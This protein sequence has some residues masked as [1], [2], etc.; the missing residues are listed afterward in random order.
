MRVAFFLL[1]IPRML[2]SIYIDNFK[3]LVNFNLNF[4]DP[5]TVLIGLNGAGKTTLL[6]ALDFLHALFVGGTNV[7]LKA[8]DW[9]PDDVF[10]SAARSEENAKDVQLSF[11]LVFAFLDLGEVEWS[12]QY[13]NNQ[14]K[15]LNEKVTLNGETITLPKLAAPIFVPQGKDAYVMVPSVIKYEGS[16]FSVLDFSQNVLLK[17]FQ[18]AMLGLRF[19]VSSSNAA[20]IS[21]TW[22]EEQRTSLLNDL[23]IFYPGVKTLA[24]REAVPDYFELVVQDQ[25]TK[26]GSRHLGRGMLRILAILAQMQTEQSCVLLEEI[27]NGINP[28]M[29]ARLVE[30]LLNAPKQVI[31]TTHSPLILNYMPDER[32]K[33]S[34]VLI[35]KNPQGIT[36]ATRFCEIP[37]IAKKL[38][39]MGP[40]DAMIDTDME[41]LVNQLNQPAPEP[42]PVS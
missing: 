12:G 32:A 41:D 29:I 18:H 40:G 30:Y 7:W 8:R 11:Q 9:T 31:F 28:E 19:L 24:M 42:S 3:S 27:E 5:L 10:S 33:E 15:V 37:K 34:V 4:N 17:K 6:Q 26:T 14:T 13:Q 39:Y 16:I 21:P 38:S 1:E 22:T 36:C 2:K 25:H 20:E 35:Y 23:K